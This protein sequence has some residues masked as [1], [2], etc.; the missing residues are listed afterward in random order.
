MQR[1]G[2]KQ[3]AIIVL[4]GLLGWALCGAIM[5]VGM[6]VMGLRTTLIV[7][8]I[9]APIIFTVISMFYYKKFHY[10]SALLTGGF[11]LAIVALMDFFLVGL[12][13]SRKRATVQ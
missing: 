6:S 11:F 4:L 10:T 5:F 3:I 1:L 8:A 12:V 13:I 7:H 9:G 2:S